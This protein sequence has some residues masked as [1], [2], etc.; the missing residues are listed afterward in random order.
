[1]DHVR[2]SRRPQVTSFRSTMRASQPATRA[3]GRSIRFHFVAAAVTR[4]A[5]RTNLRGECGALNFSEVASKTSATRFQDFWLGGRLTSGRWLSNVNS[6]RACICFSNGHE[7]G[8]RNCKL[9]HILSSSMVFLKIL[10][11]YQYIL[12]PCGGILEWERSEN[13]PPHAMA[14]AQPLAVL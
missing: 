12:E 10:H 9:C 4:K 7:V 13:A 5:V 11:A 8:P 14:P 1:M 2:F 3:I 6:T